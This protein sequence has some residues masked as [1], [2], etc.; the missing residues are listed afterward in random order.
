MKKLFLFASALVLGM[1]VF[2][3]QAQKAEDVLK[4]K[5]LSYDFGKIKQGAPV[6]HDFTFTNVSDN[7]AI[8]ESAMA[9][10]GCTTPVWSRDP[11][12]AGGT[13]KIVV[14]YNAYAEGSF[15]KTVTV[16]YNTNMTKTLT[17][18]GEVYKT[19][20]SSAPDNASVQLLKQ[21]N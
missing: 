7:P 9:S 16:V 2:A 18:S 21:I 12:E 1:S 5:E 15:T 19:P 20:A 4:F 13:A 10:C 14:G 8:I 11:I 3:Q 6:S 17:I